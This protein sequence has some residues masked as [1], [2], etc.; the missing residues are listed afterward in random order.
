MTKKSKFN[1]LNKKISFLILAI[2]VF[3]ENGLATIP[4]NNILLIYYLHKKS[5]RRASLID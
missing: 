2:L 1:R 5:I 4:N 3:R